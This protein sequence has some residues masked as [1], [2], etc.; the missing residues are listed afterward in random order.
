[1]V[2]AGTGLVNAPGGVAHCGVSS[3]WRHPLRAIRRF[4][5]NAQRYLAGSFFVGLGF[6]TFWILFNLYLKEVG[7]GEAAIGRILTLG[8]A[9]TFLTALPAA[10]LI[11]RYPTRRI[12]IGAAGLASC[13]YLLQAMPV[14]RGM[15]MLGAALA[16]SAFAVHNIAAAPFFMRNSRPDERLELFGLNSAVEIAASVIGAAGGG[17]LPRALAPHVGGLVVG[18]RLTLGVASGLVLLALLPYLQIHEGRPPRGNE[19][20]LAPYRRAPWRLIGRLITPKFLTGLGAGLV[21]P[22]LNL[23]FRNRFHLKSDRIGLFFAL[24][25]VITVFG[26]LSGPKVARRFGMI[27]AAAG[28]EILS[29]PFFVILAWTQSLPVA[30]MAFWMRGALMNMNQPI[31]DNFAMEMVPR[32]HQATTN[33]VVSLTWSGAWMISAQI[34]G[35]LIERHG[36]SPPMM[37]TVGLYLSASI[38]YLAFFHDAEARWIEPRRRAA[39]AEAAP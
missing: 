8:S 16:S 9:G 33:A 38:L 7:Y 20:F 2:S 21:I 34:G 31:S 4:Q 18:Y 3:V 27:R 37:I 29:I 39:A 32:D 5:P 15:V 26:Y 22:F 10:L 25:Q 36:F 17:W 13:G 14:G 6:G 35:W 19:S 12:V 24:A 28:T 30:V 1:M 11:N 23:Y